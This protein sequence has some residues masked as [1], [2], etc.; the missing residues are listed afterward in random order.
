MMCY[1]GMIDGTESGD[2]STW[3]EPVTNELRGDQPHRFLRRMAASHVSDHGRE[4]GLRCLSP[5]VSDQLVSRRSMKGS[6]GATTWMR[7]EFSTRPNNESGSAL[8]GAKSGA[9]TQPQW[10]SSNGVCG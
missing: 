2:G 10:Y 5:D 3:L 1:L 4:R 9:S 8:N 7:S 6:P